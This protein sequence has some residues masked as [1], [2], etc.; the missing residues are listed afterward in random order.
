MNYLYVDNFRGF[1]DTV[2]PI[3]E[4]NFLVGENST[5]K[6]S[7]LGLLKLILTPQF[8]FNQHFD[9][10]DV[11]FGHFRDIVSIHADDRR[12]FRIGFVSESQPTDMGEEVP[13][14]AFLMSFLEKE[15]LPSLVHYTVNTGTIAAH[16]RFTR[17]K[18]FL[19]GVVFD[20]PPD[21]DAFA[22]STLKD[23]IAEHRK[24]SRGYRALELPLRPT[25]EALPLPFIASIGDSI[26]RKE[27]IPSV[28]ERG[29]QMLMRR[30][31][32]DP[33]WL[34]PIRT[35]PRR[36]YDEVQLAFSPEGAHTPYLIRKILDSKTEALKFKQRIKQIG[37]TSGLFE[38][39]TIRR[40]GKTATA[41][42]ELDIVLDERALNISTVG[43][44]VSQSL[45]VIVEVL[46]R[47]K[48]SWFAIQQPEIHLH[49]RAQAALGDLF[50]E[51]CV[52]EKKRFLVET[53]SDFAIDRF[54]WNFRSTRRKKPD[55]QILFF[56]RHRRSNRVTPLRISPKGEL[57]SGQPDTYRAFFVKEQMKVLGL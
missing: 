43:Y 27:K 9:T 8:W 15:G 39:V 53:H 31:G 40:F 6:T 32:P 22:K 33:V 24:P 26:L 7:I 55:S 29:F 5:G 21:C 16:L 19:K 17:G 54:R 50:F 12:Y 45:P 4:V 52:R 37:S 11:H 46:A 38:S 36:T 48:G 35:S 10:E 44:G 47:P 51:L 25:L 30:F 57:Q 14:D 28:N 1:S 41:P 13:L 56:D 23:W 2:V 20:R 49:P 18:A 34:A 3:R 42:F